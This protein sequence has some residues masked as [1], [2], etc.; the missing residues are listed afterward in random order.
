MTP[1]NTVCGVLLHRLV[2][3]YN[4]NRH[5]EINSVCLFNVIYF[6]FFTLLNISNTTPKI[7]KYEKYK[8]FLKNMDAIMHNPIYTTA[9]I[10]NLDILFFAIP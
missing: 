2:R 9:I 6:L 8:G 5:M 4:L 10:A 3:L 7:P 1:R